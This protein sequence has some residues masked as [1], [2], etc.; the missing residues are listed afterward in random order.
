MLVGAVSTAGGSSSSDIVGEVGC[1]PH[2]ECGV[3]VDAAGE[4]VGRLRSCNTSSASFKS[5][6]VFTFTGTLQ[7]GV[8]VDSRL[9]PPEGVS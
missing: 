2:D 9:P 6:C 7:G 1:P 4:Q 3:L 8:G 5:A